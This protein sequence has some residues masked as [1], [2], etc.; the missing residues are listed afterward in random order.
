M[1]VFRRRLFFWLIKAYIKRWGKLFILCFVLGLIAFFTIRASFSYIVANIPIQNKETIGIIGD[2]TLDTLP[3]WIMQEVSYGLTIVQEDGSLKPG[4]AK[5]WNIEDGGKKYVFTLD[6]KKVFHDGTQVSA[7]EISYNFTG[8]TIQRPRDDTIIFLLKEPYTPFLVTVS[9]PIMKNGYIGLGEYK[10]KDIK[11][12]AN[13]VE[14]LSFVNTKNSYN[15][16]TFRF[17]S[18]EEALKLAFMLGEVTE[19]VGLSDLVYKETNFENFPSLEI[20]K[21]IDYQQ[22]VTLFY[23]TEDK[24]LSDEKIRGALN[25]AI[26]DT[27]A[28][29]ERTTA[30]Y[31]PY[32]WAYDAN[33]TDRK[34]DSMHAELLLKSS[35]VGKNDTMPKLTIKTLHRYKHTADEIK[36]AWKQIGI[37]VTIE[38]VDG[39]PETFQIFLGDFIVAR[40]PDQYT[41]WHTNQQANITKY[42]SL[43]IDKLLEDGRKIQNKDERKKIYADFQKYLLADAPASFLYFPYE[44]TIIR[45]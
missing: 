45:K 39:F 33:V 31:P 15:T 29:G 4:I 16:R 41:L 14:H 22:L 40:D 12:N 21:T 43:R 42:S 23:N 20:E 34:Q 27:V 28:N 1:I 2:Y 18:T 8:V 37:D 13:F 7:K 11:V 3:P 19:A 9:R 24:M 44:Y 25:Y 17:Y 10:I 32:S 38:T 6:T 30:P 26:P 5:S 35:S 36:K